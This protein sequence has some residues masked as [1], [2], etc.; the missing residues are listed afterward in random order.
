MKR[1]LQLLTLSLILG[2]VISCGTSR[3]SKIT[4]LK[5]N[6]SNPSQGVINASGD[7]LTIGIPSGNPQRAGSSENANAIANNAISKLN[8]P[9]AAAQIRLDSL[10]DVDFINKA[11]VSEML[12]IGSSKAIL[13]KANNKKVKDFAGLL[14]AEQTRAKAELDR[15]ASDKRVMLSFPKMEMPEPSS[16]AAYLN[17]IIEDHQNNIRIFESGI[18]S[19]DPEIKAFASRY[20][21]IL[22]K[23]L[24]A[25]QA[26]AKEL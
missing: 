18:K 11:A 23:Q 25:A 7:A 6:T 12:E 1:L 15:L 16:E 26:L 20:L 24:A 3:K 10:K 21:P 22:R 5:P 13:N 14:I 9:D 8:G 19:K 4:T 17:L 2:T